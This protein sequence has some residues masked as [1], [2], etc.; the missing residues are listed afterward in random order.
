MSDRNIIYLFGAGASVQYRQDKKPKIELKGKDF[1]EMPLANNFPYIVSSQY[2]EERINTIL[3]NRMN[4]ID[5]DLYLKLL[6]FSNFISE[7]NTIDEAMKKLYLKEDNLTID[8]CKHLIS[9][10]FYFIEYVD[11]YRDPRYLQFLLTI[12]DEGYLLKDS[13]SILSWNY[14]NQFEYNA[15][16]LLMMQ[17]HI[18]KK[19]LTSEN[20][21]KINGS[22]FKF[23]GSNNHHL[24]N[25]IQSSI[26]EIKFAWEKKDGQMLTNLNKFL[27]KDKFNNK[28]NIIV[29]IGYSFPAINHEFDLEILTKLKVK[30]I[31]FQSKVSEINNYSKSLKERFEGVCKNISFI[32]IKDCS[33]FY[34]PSEYFESSIIV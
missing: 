32:P 4:E 17:G 9:I 21:L 29:A 20:F 23:S 18:N 30:K 27:S 34:I 6:S 5:K 12:V 26:S 1:I 8:Q 13:V 22:A 2:Y 31:Y 16:D 28:S 10:I 24:I 14:D 3:N 19:T 15:D 7:H 33:R 11:T 25:E